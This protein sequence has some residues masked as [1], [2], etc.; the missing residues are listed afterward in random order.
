LYRQDA[1]ALREVEDTAE[2]PERAAWRR[3]RQQPIQLR[4]R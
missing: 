4:R 3:W 2:T 1:G